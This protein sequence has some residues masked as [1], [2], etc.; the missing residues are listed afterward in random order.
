MPRGKPSTVT[1]TKLNKSASSIGSG[2]FSLTQVFKTASNKEISALVLFTRVI[3]AFVMLLLRFVVDVCI[4]A[5]KS[6]NKR[7]F[8]NYFYYSEGR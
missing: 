7:E 3:C 5:Q 4:V 8:M 1:T 2:A 6:I